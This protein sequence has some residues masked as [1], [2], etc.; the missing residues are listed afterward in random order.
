[1]TRLRQTRRELLKSAAAMSAAVSFTKYGITP[2]WSATGTK[3][4]GLNAI[5]EVLRQAADAKEVPG[6]VAVAA[7]SDGVIYEG[8]FGKR[9][10]AKGTDMTPARNRIGIYRF[11]CPTSQRQAASPK[12]YRKAGC[13]TSRRD[14]VMWVGLRPCRPD[15]RTL[16]SPGSSIP[17]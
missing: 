1:M 8:A 16:Q 7:N 6:V 9:D 10:L 11:I 12:D 14:G 15:Q 3:K 5:D 17:R 4:D 13:S 2:S